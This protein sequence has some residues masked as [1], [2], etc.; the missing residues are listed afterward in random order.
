MGLAKYGDRYRRHVGQV[1]NLQDPKGTPGSPLRR[2]VNRLQ[3]A[4]YQS[5][6]GCHP[7]GAWPGAGHLKVMKTLVGQAILPA[8]RLSSRPG[9][10]KGGLQPGLAAPRSAHGRFSTVPHKARPA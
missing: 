7:A 3:R 8:G 9:R 1:V 10:L 6:A 5:A 4:D 2:A